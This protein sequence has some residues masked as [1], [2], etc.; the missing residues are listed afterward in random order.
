MSGRSFYFDP[1]AEG[2]A[3][4]MGPTE[5]AL[6][7]LAWRHKTLTVKKTI[8]LLEPVSKPAYTTVMTVLSRLADKGL[9]TRK[10]DGRN[11][12]YRP[13]LDRKSYVQNRLRLIRSCLRRNFRA[14]L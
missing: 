12:I 2:L 11:Y 7:E 8:R 4:F 1:E 10:L 3:V 6:M 9:L 13:G 5:A 14:C